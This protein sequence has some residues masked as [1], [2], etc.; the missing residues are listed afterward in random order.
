MTEYTLDKRNE[1]RKTT[2]F[3][4]TNQLWNISG[5]NRRYSVGCTNYL[6]K[7]FYECCNK[8]KAAN[9]TLD[10]WFLYYTK[11]KDIDKYKSGRNKTELK[12]IAKKFAKYCKKYGIKITQEEAYNYVIIRVVDDTFY[13]YQHELKMIDVIEN[14]IWPGSTVFCTADEDV[15]YAV[16]LV[17][18]YDDV[19]IDAF[20]I[21][22]ISFFKGI[23]QRNNY[24]I[25]AFLQNNSKH[26]KYY[27]K[28]KTQ[29][30]FLFYDSN[31][32]DFYK[33]MDRQTIFKE[34]G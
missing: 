30:L 25:T 34:W 31:D 20:Q 5:L 13:G 3:K 6:I 8:E 21:K 22:P 2:K 1:I 29:P 15:E 18:Y 24:C 23:L 14:E 11:H 7:K 28:N 16:D 32:D 33:I 10:D 26:D 19:L 4:N 27:D 9:K 17:A 12:E